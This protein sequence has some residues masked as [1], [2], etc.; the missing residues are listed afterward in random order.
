MSDT[1]PFHDAKVAPMADA[2][3]WFVPVRRAVRCL[4]VMPSPAIITHWRL[5]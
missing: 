1:Y 5:Q 4:I 3:D 2:S